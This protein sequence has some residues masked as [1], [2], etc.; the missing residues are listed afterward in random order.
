MAFDGANIWVTNHSSD[1]APKIN[2]GCGSDLCLKSTVLVGSDPFGVAFDGTNIW[3]ANGGSGNVSRS[4]RSDARRNRDERAEPDGC[5]AT[6][7]APTPRHQRARRLVSCCRLDAA[8]AVTVN[9]RRM[10]GGPAELT[11][12]ALRTCPVGDRLSDTRWSTDV[13]A[14]LGVQMPMGK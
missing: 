1:L 6:R 14:L 7:R 13:V 5:D 3:G 4:S 12:G 2:P 9:L 10:V 11:G 8:D